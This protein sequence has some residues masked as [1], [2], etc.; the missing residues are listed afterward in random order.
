MTGYYILSWTERGGSTGWRPEGEK[1]INAG[2]GYIPETESM[3][4]SVEVRRG[5]FAISD[6]KGCRHQGIFER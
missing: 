6:K 5:M 1:K 2:L 4:N 3:N